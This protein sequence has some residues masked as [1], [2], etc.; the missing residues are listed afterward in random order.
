MKHIKF[1]RIVVEYEKANYFSFI[2]LINPL[3]IIFIL[4]ETNIIEPSFEM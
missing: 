4:R 1:E 2:I 3:K